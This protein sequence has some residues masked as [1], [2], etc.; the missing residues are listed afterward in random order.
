MTI[1]EYNK[2]VNLYA[3]RLFRFVVKNV[4]DHHFAEDIVQDSYEKMW[5]NVAQINGEKVKTYL[6]TTAYHTL[7]D[8][9]RKEKR[10]SF[11]EEL[12]AGDDSYSSRFPDVAERLNEAVAKLP[13]IQR[14]VI[15]L[16]DYEGYSYQEIGEMTGL[17]ESQVKV[18]IYRA[19][20]FLKNYIGKIDVLI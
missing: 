7:I 8:R 10:M 20:L 16:R 17:G 9:L 1:E 11:A 19:R 13:E 2:S 15:T 6:F 5:K 18:Y 4:K 14:I 3:D 12:P